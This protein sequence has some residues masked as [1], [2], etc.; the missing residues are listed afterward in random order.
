MKYNDY[1]KTLALKQ[2]LDKYRFDAGIGGA[3]LDEEMS[4]AKERIFSVRNKQ[5][6]WDPKN[7]RP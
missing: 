4:R 3:R 6:I 5:H 7:Q 1:M 2:A